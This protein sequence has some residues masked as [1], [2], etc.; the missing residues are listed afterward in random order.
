MTKDIK[1]FG[2]KTTIGLLRSLTSQDLK[3]VLRAASE[4]D[5]IGQ[6][7]AFSDVLDFVA[8]NDLVNI[9]SKDMQIRSVV[10]ETMPA[11]LAALERAAK[12]GSLEHLTQQLKARAWK[13]I[14]VD[15]TDAGSDLARTAVMSAMD[16]YKTLYDSSPED[17]VRAG[18]NLIALSTVARQLDAPVPMTIDRLQLATTVMQSLN[19]VPQALRGLNFHTSKAEAFVALDDLTSAE[20]E[21]GKIVRNPATT[22]AN[23]AGMIRQLGD[24]WGLKGDARGDGIVQALGAVLLSKDYDHAMLAPA[25]VKE[26]VQKPAPS[27]FQLEAILGPDGPQ[28]FQ[29]YKQGL[30]TA[31]SVGVVRIAGAA[32]RV[33]TGFVVRGGDII[34]DLGDEPCLLTNSHVVSDDPDDHLQSEGATS[35]PPIYRED[36]EVVFEGANKG[37][38]YRFCSI[39]SWTIKTL[40]AAILRFEGGV[41]PAKPL[42]LAKRLPLADGK[43]RVYVIGYP[44]GGELSYSLEN[45]RLLDHEGPPQGVP[46]DNPYR[47]VQY[48][49]PTEGGSS[50]SPVFNGHNWQVIALHHAGGKNIPRLNR[51][52]GRWPANEGIWIQS[53]CEAGRAASTA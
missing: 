43:Q 33:G 29:W 53:I 24:V 34:P 47:R 28:T 17:R 16:E 41:P 49:A 26:L 30:E 18:L 32:T 38:G 27:D 2:D 51:K 42:S 5:Q 8:K 48:E 12:D 46:T 25:R 22:A 23:I 36:A 40:D 6:S 11:A 31:L 3:S 10:N 21:I 9:I 44:G 1:A 19:E 39:T 14:V 45:N 52:Q 50:G 35:N 20:R 37:V 15:M 7:T 4:T 13:D